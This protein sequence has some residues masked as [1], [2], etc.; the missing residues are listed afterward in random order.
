MLIISAFLNFRNA[1]LNF[2]NAVKMRFRPKQP[3]PASD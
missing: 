2:R 1:L 3:L